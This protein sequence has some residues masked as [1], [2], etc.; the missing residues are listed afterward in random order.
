MIDAQGKPVEGATV[1]FEA[2]GVNRKAQT[3]TDKNG[4]FLQVGLQ[5]GPYKVTATKEGVGTQNLT[6]NVR[7]GPNDPLTLQPD[8]PPAACRPPT[9]KTRCACRLPPAPRWRR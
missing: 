9:R 3:K 2:E 4:E 1:T 5:S 8:A 7:Q 6:A